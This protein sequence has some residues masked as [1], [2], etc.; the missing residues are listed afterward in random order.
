MITFKIVEEYDGRL[1]VFNVVRESNNIDK[2]I[3][4]FDSYQDAEVY[5]TTL[6]R[7]NKITPCGEENPCN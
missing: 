7:D 5:I 2:V 1:P 6:I 4:T 3:K